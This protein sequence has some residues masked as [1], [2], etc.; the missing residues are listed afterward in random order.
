[1]RFEDL[2]AQKRAEIATS[3]ARKNATMLS[4]WQ[5]ITQYQS[6]TWEH[7]AILAT[8]WL[9]GCA[10]VS[11]IGCGKM[12]LEQH[13]RA[14]VSYVPIDV[15][16]HDD[17]TLVIDLNQEE[18]R[19][20]P[21]TEAAAVLGT[22]E[23]LYDLPA[24]IAALS[25][26]YSTVVL[27]YCVTDLTP[28]P[29]ARLSHGWVNNWSKAD[30]EQLLSQQGW[31][32]AQAQ[33]LDEMQWLWHLVRQKEENIG[34]DIVFIGGTGRSGTS[35]VQE[36]LAK[37][38]GFTD[39]YDYEA[40]F[41]IEHC[42]LIDLYEAY[43][44]PVT[45]ADFAPRLELFGSFLR[46][47]TRA[48]PH[49]GASRA[50]AV[51]GA[52]IVEAAFE[53]FSRTLSVGIHELPRRSTNFQVAAEGLLKDLFRPSGDDVIVEKTPYSSMF[54]PQ[55]KRIFPGAKFVM[56][57]REPRDTL[58]SYLL[59]G[60]G[61]SDP[62]A[63]AL[64][65]GAVMDAFMRA[66]RTHAG[67]LADLYVMDADRIRANAAPLSN[68]LTNRFKR[69]LFVDSAAVDAN[70]R[71]VAEYLA[72]EGPSTARAEAFDLDQGVEYLSARIRNIRNLMIV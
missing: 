71:F 6:K 67:W 62:M 27:S 15:V 9:L 43:T 36:I 49:F 11:D 8:Q 50:V 12:F 35:S 45:P 26:R 1:M 2:D 17:R 72:R 68:W 28:D 59:Q 32:V 46:G 61:Y 57:F 54:M 39:V 69:P 42:G 25:N 4:R 48:M 51:F 21:E 3:F 55:L 56:T 33:R 23:Y 52:E 31:V 38:K 66:T 24:F 16:S 14:N 47:D 64:Q 30:F 22:L 10:S 37:S 53:R 5:Q 41:L 58:A 65:L 29:R 63:A 7:R 20:G 44:R 70:E 13:L 60:W 19:G 34:F 18:L 40:R